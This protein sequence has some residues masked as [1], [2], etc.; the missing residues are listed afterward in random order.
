VSL[1]GSTVRAA[2]AHADE[3]AQHRRRAG[4]LVIL[5]VLAISLWAAYALT[6]AENGWTVIAWL[7]F[8]ASVA[9]TLREPRHGVYITVFCALLADGHTMPWFPFTKN[10]SSTESLLFIGS[11]VIFS[12]LE[13]FLVLTSLIWLGKA[14]LTRRLR[15]YQGPL[16]WPAVSFACFIGVGL[17][18]GIG[19]GGNLNIALWEARTIFYLPLMLV[20]AMNLLETRQQVSRLFWFVMIA[21]FLHGS[22]G[23]WYLIVVKGGHADRLKSLVEHGAAVRM[24]TLFVLCAAAWV[25]RG[26]LGQRLLLPLFIPPVLVTYLMAQRRAAFVTLALGLFVV[27][28]VLFHRRPRTFFAIAPPLFILFVAYVFAFSGSSGP[29]GLP[30]R[31]VK[32]IILPHAAKEQEA[33]SDAYR[34]IENINTLYTIQHTSPLT[35]VGFGNKFLVIVPLPDIS[36]FGWWEYITHNSML[37]IWMKAGLGGFFSLLFLVGR[38]LFVG[39]RAVTTAPNDNTSPLVLTAF[40]YVLMHVVYAY[41]DMSWEAQSM[42]YVGACL[43]LLGAFERIIRQPAPTLQD[44]YPWLGHQRVCRPTLGRSERAPQTRGLTRAAQ[45]RGPDRLA[46]PRSVRLWSEVPGSRQDVAR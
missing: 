16:L 8:G 39:A 26:S 37:W 1:T 20:L 24:N 38:A 25:L 41:V 22:F 44:R 11:S 12:P 7:V 3:E 17:V 13:V 2:S 5:A 6:Q 28:G 32:S 30:A 27:G 9:A 35:G 40:A 36:F 46:P 33:G 19:R 23:L 42:T 31:A 10:F 29:L 4:I 21:I 43:G 15:V 34:V 18:Y 14:A 45:D